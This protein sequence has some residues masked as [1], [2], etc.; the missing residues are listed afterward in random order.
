MTLKELAAAELAIW[1][2]DMAE[3]NSKKLAE[4]A[5]G[6]MMIKGMYKAEAERD[7]GR[8]VTHYRVNCGFCRVDA[9]RAAHDEIMEIDNHQDMLNMLHG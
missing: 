6:R 4:L 1:K 9:I 8:L 3:E 5:I 7:F 2:K